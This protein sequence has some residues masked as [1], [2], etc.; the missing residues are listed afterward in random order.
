MRAPRSSFIRLLAAGV[1]AVW[2]AVLAQEVSKPATNYSL[3]VRADKPGAIYRRGEEVR[4]KVKLL[5]DR[6]PVKE[7]MIEWTLSRTG[8]RRYARGSSALPTAKA[9]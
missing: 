3:T 7:G 9:Q 8:F 2:P 5:L 6:Q 1:V 4:F